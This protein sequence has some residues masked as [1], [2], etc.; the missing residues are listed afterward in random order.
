MSKT[1]GGERMRKKVVIVLDGA[2][3]GDMPKPS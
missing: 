3:I 1:G 2:G